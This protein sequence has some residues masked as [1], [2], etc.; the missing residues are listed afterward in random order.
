M[1]RGAGGGVRN[2]AAFFDGVFDPASRIGKKKQ[3]HI[4]A[5]NIFKTT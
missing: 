5:F 1:Y 4:F 3:Q 2:T